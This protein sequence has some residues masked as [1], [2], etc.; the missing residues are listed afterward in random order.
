MN[1]LC[2]QQI[3]QIQMKQIQLIIIRVDHGITGKYEFLILE[4]LIG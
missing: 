3:M 2:I 4:R 1:I